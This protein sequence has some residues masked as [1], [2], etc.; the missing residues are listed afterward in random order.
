VPGVLA[1]LRAR[2]FTLATVTDQFGGALPGSGLVS[3][4][5]R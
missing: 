5:P 2:G 3:H 4:G 1:G